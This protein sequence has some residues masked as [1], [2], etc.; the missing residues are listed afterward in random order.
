MP[1]FGHLPQVHPPLHG[2]APLSKR[3]KVKPQV[4]LAGSNPQGQTTFAKK[5]GW[6]F[7]HGLGPCLHNL[8]WRLPQARPL[9]LALTPLDSFK[10]HS[11]PIPDSRSPVLLYAA[12][13]ER[14]L[15]RPVMYTAIIVLNSFSPASLGDK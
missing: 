8:R 9:A 6:T 2:E 1:N 10:M 3:P 11:S 15:I 4:H 13:R 14:D 5:H 12:P 7:L